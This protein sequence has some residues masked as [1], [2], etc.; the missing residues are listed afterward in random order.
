MRGVVFIAAFLIALVGPA[1]AQQGRSTREVEPNDA[2]L[3]ATVAHLGDTISGTIN[4]SD[5]DYF[6]VDL[7]AG[8]QLELI[9][10]HVPFCRDFACWIR[11][12]PTHCGVISRGTG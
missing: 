12:E 11:R 6:A 7:E 3:T 2:A 1:A 8:A 9:A 10:A 4:P 5:V